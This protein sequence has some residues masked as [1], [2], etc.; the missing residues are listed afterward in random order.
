MTRISAEKLAAQWTQ[1]FA[2]VVKEASGKDGRLSLS[3]ASRIPER[4]DS[5]R[6]WSDNAVNALVGLGQKTISAEKL[7]D[8]RRAVR[9]RRGE[10][11]RGE[12][13]VPLRER[14]EAAAEGSRRRLRGPRGQADRRGSADA[15]AAP[16]GRARSGAA[17]AR[18]AVR[19][20]APRSSRV[21]EGP[22]A[23]PERARAPRD[24]DARRRLRRRRTG[25]RL[26][27]VGHAVALR[28]VVPDRQPPRSLDRPRRAAGCDR[29]GDGRALGDER[30]RRAGPLRRSPRAPRSRA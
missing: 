21:G 19:A 16:G 27:R 18:W 30:V 12:G 23:A 7:V 9:A 15:R 22:Q 13:R 17:H 28:R 5:G 29:R 24:E 8:A 20:A 10:A 11:G 14:G 6:L 4:L 2:D 3:E 1:R 26:P 25:L